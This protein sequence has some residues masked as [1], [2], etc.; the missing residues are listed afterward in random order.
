MEQTKFS[1]D[2]L[3]LFSERLLFLLQ[4][5]PPWL[6][7]TQS[8]RYA[9][10][11][12]E[13]EECCHE[14][15]SE[16]EVEVSNVHRLQDVDPP[17]QR[18]DDRE[19]KEIVDNVPGVEVSVLLEDVEDVAHSQPAA[20]GRVETEHEEKFLVPPPYTVAEEEAMMVQNINAPPAGKCL[21]VCGWEGPGYLQ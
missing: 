7:T 15:S 17:C 18:V 3:K 10:Q 1:K 4:L 20:D 13:E 12:D 11:A 9:D 5:V 19:G 2:L 14:E 21:S 16:P 8:P 6:V